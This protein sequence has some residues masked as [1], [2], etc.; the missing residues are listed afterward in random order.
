MKTESVTERTEKKT[1]GEMPEQT[2]E[3]LFLYRREGDGIVITG[4]REWK[5]PKS[6]GISGTPETLESAKM[7]VER[8]GLKAPGIPEMSEIRIPAE[9]AGMPV[10]II[11]KSAFAFCCGLRKVMLPD[12]VVFVGPSAFK[13]CENLE[14]AVLSAGLSGIG[15]L[16]FCR[17]VRLRQVTIP[18]ELSSIE[19]NSFA[20]C[21]SLERIRVRKRT[22]G[23]GGAAE[24]ESIRDFAVA[25][26]SELLIWI[27]LRAVLAAAGGEKGMR[28]YDEAYMG[29]RSRADLFRIAVFRLRD[30][31]DLLPEAEV[32]Y[33]NTL[34]SMVPSLISE[35]DIDRL[36]VVGEVRAI[37]PDSLDGYIELAGK[38]SGRC[39]A[40][41]LEYKRRNEIIR[42]RDFSL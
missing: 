2:E 9:I 34:N 6:A 17:C 16:A 5:K 19:N 28:G 21:V 20:G 32:V 33:K 40:Y 39:L 41:L 13:G 31:G 27:Y 7:P 15:A 8:K 30:P 11:G 38:R 1:A 18:A 36:N 37:A 35:D 22:G 23:D 12:S 29:V 3:G 25:S 4:L 42:T 14:E 26:E 24:E 10:R